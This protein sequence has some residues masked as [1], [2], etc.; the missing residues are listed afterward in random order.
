MKI[1]HT[2][3][4]LKDMLRQI[5]ASYKKELHL[6]GITSKLKILEEKRSKIT[7]QISKGIYL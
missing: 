4:E 6:K 7:S 1:V 2:H 5:N 3:N